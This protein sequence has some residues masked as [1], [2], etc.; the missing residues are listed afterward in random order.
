[1]ISKKLLSFFYRLFSIFLICSVCVLFFTSL[2]VSALV[3]NAD[4][5]T[6]WNDYIWVYTTSGAQR[7]ASEQFGNSIY[8]G[9]DPI[10][11]LTFNVSL[12][13]Y[14]EYGNFTNGN[15]QFTLEAN[16]YWGTDAGYSNINCEVWTASGANQQRIPSTMGVMNGYYRSSDNPLRHAVD[17]TCNFEAVNKKPAYVVIRV[18]DNHNGD[19]GIV[20]LIYG[21]NQNGGSLPMPRVRNVSYHYNTSNESLDSASL[22]QIES[23]TGDLINGQKN[24]Y[25]NIT[26][27][28]DKINNSINQQTQ[29]I[30]RGNDIAQE[31][32]DYL[33][34]DTEPD[35]DTS[36]LSGSAGWLPAG[37]VDSILTLPINFIQAIIQ[38]L[39]S[40]NCYPV[41]L[42]LPY[43][44]KEL[45]LPC[46]RP[47]LNAM[48]FGQ[49]Y[50][51]V[52]SV[53][54][55]FIIWNTLKWLYEFVDKTLTFREDNSSIWGG[56]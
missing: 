6:A 34:D 26:N 31:T 2:P 28:G 1:M 40:S 10:N 23:N 56:L 27:Q 55:M 30:E 32:Q 8:N 15:V 16:G 7:W 51:V 43:V 38:A 49:I 14:G 46:M 42:P 18:G 41:I 37:P 17:Y 45:T 4:I 24:I 50:E 39:S 29:E 19:S 5:S 33:M 21:Y 11:G 53:V 13:W 12:D 54:A 22:N 35:V 3:G 48:G 44:N 36:V 20:P 9:L 47:I 52:G 25:D